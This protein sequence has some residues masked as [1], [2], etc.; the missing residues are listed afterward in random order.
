[1]VAV[2]ILTTNRSPR[3]GGPAALP[4]GYPSLRQPM[5]LYYRID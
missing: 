2:P 1:M 4:R 5:V 3:H